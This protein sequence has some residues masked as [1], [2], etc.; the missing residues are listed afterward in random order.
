M[1]TGLGRGGLLQAGWLMG[2]GGRLHVVHRAY[3]GASC[4]IP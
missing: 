3:K 4:V 2:C 1:R